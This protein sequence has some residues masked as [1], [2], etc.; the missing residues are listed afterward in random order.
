MVILFSGVLLVFCGQTA[1][2]KKTQH[3]SLPDSLPVH[4]LYE[5]DSASSYEAFR[6]TTLLKLRSNEE[7]LLHLHAEIGNSGKQ[8]NAKYFSV[9]LVLRH[10]NNALRSRVTEYRECDQHNW[11]AFEQDFL[12][13]MEQLNR[14]IV[15]LQLA[16]EILV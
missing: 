3:L 6:Q 15:N 11:V 10:R 1:R 8:E 12:S 7:A 9:L 4:K 13:D 2:V 5:P 16:K 14:V